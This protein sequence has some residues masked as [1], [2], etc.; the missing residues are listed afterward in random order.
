MTNHF[1][2]TAHMILQYTLFTQ[3]YTVQ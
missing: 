2:P 1:K 3:T